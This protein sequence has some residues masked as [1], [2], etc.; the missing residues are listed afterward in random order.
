MPG[1]LK[2]SHLEEK[3]TVLSLG[4]LI[5]LV[6]CIGWVYLD[7]KFDHIDEQLQDIRSDLASF[8][9]DMD[10]ESGNMRSAL[11]SFRSDM[12]TE[13]G[14]VRSDMAAAFDSMRSDMATEFDSMRSEFRSEISSI[15]DEIK[16][17]REATQELRRQIRSIEKILNM[18]HADTESE[19]KI[20]SSNQQ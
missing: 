18:S 14:N 5:I 4:V 15:R 9:L 2:E 12:A 20:T 7:S 11:T 19:S 10:T 16:G 3:A 6:F 13:L 1:N 8:R 17:A